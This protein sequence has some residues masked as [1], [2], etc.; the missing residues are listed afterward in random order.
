[1]ER[2]CPLGHTCS[3]CLWEVEVQKQ[4]TV[5]GELSVT[6]SCALPELVQA[7]VA[8][9]QAQHSTGAAIEDFRNRMVDGNR[10]LAQLV[11]LDGGAGK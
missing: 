11:T 3:A 10:Q 4:H 6:K 9:Y 7:Q 5:T 1:M 2:T 8:V